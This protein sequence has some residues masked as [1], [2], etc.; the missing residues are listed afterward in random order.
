M[1]YPAVAGS[2]YPA[3]EGALRQQIEDAFTSKIGPGSI[4]ALGV[5]RG[6]IV[7]AV[8][9][10]AGYVYSGPVAAHVYG[11]IA[12]EGFP[13]TFV[14]IGPNHHGIGTGVAMTTE[15]FVTPLGTCQ[16]DKPLAKKL[17]GWVDDDPRAHQHEHSVE[18]QIPFLQYFSRAVKFLPITM[19]A[20]DVMTAKELGVTLRKACQG[21]EVIV[22]ASSDFSHY[23]PPGI[24]LKQDRAVID[25]ILA[26]DAPGVEAVVR[27]KNI[28]MCGCGPVMAMLEA[29]EG[30]SAELLRYATSGELQPMREVVGYAGIVVRK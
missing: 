13:E 3:K 20:Q 18:V 5:G 7:G 9:P 30:G 6:N 8:V 16:V 17:A 25:K 26:L 27:A 29:V 12:Q 19:L 2:F 15:D 21:K 23:V 1:R 14:I 24:A 4:P 11:R 28:S 22:L 10:H